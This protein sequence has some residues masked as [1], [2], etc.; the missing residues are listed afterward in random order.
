M[1]T[2]T[3]GAG[4]NTPAKDAIILDTKNLR[5]RDYKNMSGRAGRIKYH[6]DFGRS[7]LIANTPREF[8]ALWE[9]Y[10][11]APA[12]R[13]TSQIAKADIDVQI[14]GLVS[15]GSCKDRPNNFVS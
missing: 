14:L 4:I 15:S 5:V 9:S 6:D 7:I 13:V 12:E 8:E 3:L 2:S 11:E 10:V 1:A